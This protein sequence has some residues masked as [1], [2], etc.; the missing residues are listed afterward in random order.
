MFGSG[1]SSVMKFNRNQLAK[2]RTFENISEN[3][4]ETDR[5]I[6]DS[7]MTPAQFERFKIELQEKKRIQQFKAAL[8]IFAITFAVTTV[9][10]LVLR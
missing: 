2:R 6:A 7:K 8:L 1:A 5:V 3:Y 10:I 9:F 4:G